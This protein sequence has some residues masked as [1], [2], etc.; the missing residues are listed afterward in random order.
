LEVLSTGKGARIMGTTSRGIFLQIENAWLVFLSWERWRGPLTVNLDFRLEGLD[1]H[2]QVRLEGGMLRLGG[3]RI[4]LSSEKPW[5]P[6]PPPWTRSSPDERHARARVLLEE[7]RRSGR[8]ST[9]AYLLDQTVPLQPES[10]LGLGPG[11]TPSGDDLLV[12]ALLVRARRETVPP[13]PESLL[14]AARQRTTAL[15][16]NL[17]ELAARGLADERLINLADHVNAGIPC[18]HTFLDWGAHSGVD[19]LLGM[20]LEERLSALWS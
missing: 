5:F 4:L 13:P 17:L 18:E 16:S 11:L 1:L 9:L 19:A 7:A 8:V 20:A 2:E 3:Y 10:L 14:E 15:A 12:G 6:P